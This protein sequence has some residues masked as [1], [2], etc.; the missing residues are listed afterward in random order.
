VARWFTANG[1][2]YPVPVTTASGVAAVQQFFEGMGLAKPPSVEL[3]ETEARFLC[4][5]PEAAEGEVTL[6]TP[7]RKWVYA[8]VE[9]DVPWLKVKT[10]A[11][12]GPQHA[13][14]GYT[15]DSGLLDAGRMHDGN[16][17]VIANAGQ[18]LKLHVVADVRQPQVPFTR[19]LL[20]PFLHVVLLALLARLVL[21]VPADLYARV[22]AA[23]PGDDAGSFDTW[24]VSPLARLDLAVPFIRHVVLATW[25][26]G[27]VAGGVLL[28]RRGGR[29]AD[30]VCGTIAGAVAGVLVSATF[31]CI[32]PWADG[33]ARALWRLLARAVHGGELTTSPWLW[34]PV[35]VLVVVLT[36][37]VLAT[38]PAALRALALRR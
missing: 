38:V 22:L 29:P 36:W 10:P 9:A 27:A 11:V 1:W 16:L 8:Q 23:P 5:H 4:V 17:H 32:E 33:P 3:S 35:W 25:W 14:I 31:A 20:R 21:A 19:R 26:L 18:R 2:A 6:R 34:T 24:L 13:A 7:A 28:W 12:S 15:V 37:G 30:V